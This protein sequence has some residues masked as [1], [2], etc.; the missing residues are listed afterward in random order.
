MEDTFN[1]GESIETCC[2]SHRKSHHSDQTKYN[3]VTRL[4]RIE[5]QVR[6]V[7]NLIEKILTVMM[8]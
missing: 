2:S 8:C 5:G 6:G 1:Q 3:L 7:K 4:N